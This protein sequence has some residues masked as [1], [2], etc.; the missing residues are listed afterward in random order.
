MRLSPFVGSPLTYRPHE[1]PSSRAGAGERIPLADNSDDVMQS[2]SGCG[3]VEVS[4]TASGPWRVLG[5]QM[6]RERV[7][8]EIVALVT[9]IRDRES[10]LSG[11]T[12]FG[13]LKPET[14]DR[15]SSACPLTTG[16][17]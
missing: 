13:R 14:Q 11:S 15:D 16:S 3:W 9:H 2:L 17:R 1:G 6:H 5:W 4:Q 8:P 7:A 10:L 12:D